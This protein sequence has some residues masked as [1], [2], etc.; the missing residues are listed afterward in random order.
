MA[1]NEKAKRTGIIVDKAGKGVS[2]QQAC[3]KSFG[4]ADS[5][6]SLILVNLGGLGDGVAKSG[7]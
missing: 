4:L 5:V 6:A 7:R 2:L 3:V 1:S